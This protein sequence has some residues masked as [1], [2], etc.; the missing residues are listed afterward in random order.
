MDFIGN[1][2]RAYEVGSQAFGDYERGKKVRLGQ[3]KGPD[4]IKKLG[5]YNKQGKKLGIYHA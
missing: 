5:H 2:Q 4:N 3:Y 1:L